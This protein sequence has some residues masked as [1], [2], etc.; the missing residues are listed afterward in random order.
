MTKSRT[1]FAKSFDWRG[2]IL[3][4]GEKTNRVFVTY[5]RGSFEIFTV[6]TVDGQSLWIHFLLDLQ[7]LTNYIKNTLRFVIAKNVASKKKKKNVRREFRIFNFVRTTV[8]I[9]L[10][11]VEKIKYL[12]KMIHEFFKASP[13]LSIEKWRV[14]ENFSEIKCLVKM[15]HEPLKIWFCSHTCYKKSFFFFFFNTYERWV[16]WFLFHSSLSSCF[17]FPEH[18]FFVR[19]WFIAARCPIQYLCNTLCELYRRS[20]VHP[21][22]HVELCCMSVTTDSKR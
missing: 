21:S 3:S 8:K 7:F 1:I 4:L 20:T 10:K 9:R 2:S 11:F 5:I 19:L 15:I 12:A 14:F 18:F 16:T 13:R 22:L 17:V 6:K